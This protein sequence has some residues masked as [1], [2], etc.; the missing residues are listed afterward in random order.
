MNPQPIAIPSAGH[1]RVGK[2]VIKARLPPKATA[3]CELGSPSP[4]VDHARSEKARNTYT[5]WSIGRSLRIISFK[6]SAISPPRPALRQIDMAAIFN[7]TLPLSTL[8]LK[9]DAESDRGNDSAIE[10]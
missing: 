3:A 7:D 9:G 2:I 8:S 5:S 6:N 1:R 4:L 10:I